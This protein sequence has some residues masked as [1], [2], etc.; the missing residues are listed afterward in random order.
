[1]VVENLYDQNNLT[2]TCHT[3]CQKTLFGQI[4][5]QS[6]HNK[7]NDLQNSNAN[8]RDPVRYAIVDSL[9]CTLEGIT[10]QYELIQS[11]ISQI[12]QNS[13]CMRKT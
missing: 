6:E 4:S 11:H 10:Y 3:G 9:D 7:Q 1:M 13:I 5:K 12:I 2:K 8:M